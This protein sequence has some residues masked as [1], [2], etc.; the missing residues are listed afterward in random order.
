ME[1]NV[2]LVCNDCMQKKKDKIQ[3]VII[4]LIGDAVDRGEDFFVKKKF[5]YQ[6]L[7][8]YMWVAVSYADDKM[9][10]GSLNNEPNLV[11]NIEC[12]DY[13]EL[14]YSEVVDFLTNNVRRSR[15]NN[16]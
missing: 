10:C 5:E 8:E 7:S 9:I 6:G 3:A 2:R 14:Y 4:E 1:D 11:K 13:V 12:G 15:L 16:E